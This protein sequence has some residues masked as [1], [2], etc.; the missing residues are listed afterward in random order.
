MPAGRPSKYSEA[1]ANRICEEIADGKTVSEIC[2]AEDMPARSTVFKW[3]S[4]HEE[5]SD[6]YARAREDQVERMADE[7]LEIADD[8]TNDYMERQNDDGSTYEVF[9][10]EHVQRSRLRVDT[11][12]WLMSKML[13]KKY[14]DKQEVNHSG[15]VTVEIVRFSDPNT[16]SQ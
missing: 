5:F 10:G 9:N 4:D 3:L 2:A 1:M 12:K 13:P 14:G 16:N 11:R 8:G 7:L 15:A 6:Q